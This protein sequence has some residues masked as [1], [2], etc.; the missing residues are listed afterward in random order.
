[1]VA[2]GAMVAMGT[3][4]AMVAMVAMQR[5]SGGGAVGTMV[6]M[7][8]GSGGGAVGTMVAM[9]RGGGVGSSG[10]RCCSGYRKVGMCIVFVGRVGLLGEL[11]EY[12]IAT[13]RVTVQV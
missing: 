3:M 12:V 10:I 4:V 9:H 1:M 2:M 8:R 7:H 11:G 13:Q 5:G 6:A